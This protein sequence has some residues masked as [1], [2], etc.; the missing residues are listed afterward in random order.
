MP[1]PGAALDAIGSAL[2][3]D[4]GGYVSDGYAVAS[5]KAPGHWLIGVRLLAPGSSTRL[6]FSAT[7]LD[8]ESL[9]AS[10]LPAE[11]DAA[12][13]TGWGDADDPPSRFSDTDADV[14]AAEA[15][16]PA[17]PHGREANAIPPTYQPL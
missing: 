10:L 13:Y 16:V 2:T 1:L 12:E 7:G 11:P 4:D 8:P 9:D 14:L 5:T 3:V 6:V 15:C 17:D